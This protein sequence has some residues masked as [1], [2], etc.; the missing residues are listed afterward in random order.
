MSARPAGPSHANDD[1]HAGV[2]SRLVSLAKQPVPPKVAL[3]NVLRW[4]AKHRALLLQNT[5][6]KAYGPTILGGPFSGMSF[7]RQVAEGCCVPKLLGCYEEELHPHIEEAITRDYPQLLNIGVA[8]GYY[9]VGLARRM[10][11]TKVF[12]YDTNENAQKTC[13][14]VAQANAVAER[15]H[16]GGLFRGEDFELYAGARTLLICDIEGAERELLDPDAYPALRRMDIIVELHDC[17][18]PGLSYEIPERFAAS[19]DIT[20]VR[21]AGRAVPLPSV[22]E[23]LSHLDQ[24]LAV[25]EWR[26]GPT[27]WAIMLARP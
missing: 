5:L 3:L 21:Q 25:W 4:A 26:S 22:F 11:N 9:A 19:H 8:E 12:A 2:L 18:I 6:L 16:I 20:L 17:L 23:T 15:V 27:P 1:F 14:A 7:V 24:L 10:P 13:A